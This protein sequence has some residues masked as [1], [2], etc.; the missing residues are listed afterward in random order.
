MMTNERLEAGRKARPARADDAGATAT[1]RLNPRVESARAL[2]R[3]LKRIVL[4]AQKRASAMAD[5]SPGDLADI[6]RRARQP[7]P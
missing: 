4:E 7:R 1:A 2:N 3:D 6:V 5:A